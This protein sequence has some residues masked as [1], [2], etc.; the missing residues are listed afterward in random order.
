MT[1]NVA[2]WPAETV[3]LCGSVTI[4]GLDLTVSVA[5]ELVALPAV[6]VTTTK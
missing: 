2:S 4:I 5:F 3:W 6:L 1:V